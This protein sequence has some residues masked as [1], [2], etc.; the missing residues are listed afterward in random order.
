MADVRR[1]QAA[2]VDAELAEHPAERFLAAH[3]AALRVAAII[4]S[5]RAHGAR[6]RLGNVWQLLA[7]NAPEFAEWA[8]F[9]SATQLKCQAVAAGAVALVTAREAD[10]LLRDAQAFYAAVVRRLSG[11]WQPYVALA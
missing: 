2:L 6:N 9:F 4:L 7:R 5:V 11:Q 3:G 10:D 8:S 1:A